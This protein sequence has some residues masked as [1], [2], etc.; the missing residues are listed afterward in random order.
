MIG[1]KLDEV[2]KMSKPVTAA[3]LKE[4]E[5]AAKKSAEQNWSQMPQHRKIID[6]VSKGLFCIRDFPLRLKH[7]LFAKC[8]GCPR[9]CNAWNSK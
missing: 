3:E 9:R 2:L 4:K 5:D 7:T 8:I 1:T 6:K